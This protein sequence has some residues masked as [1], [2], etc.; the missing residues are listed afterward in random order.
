MKRE[1]L[2]GNCG[3]YCS[4]LTTSWVPNVVVPHV[5]LQWTLSRAYRIKISQIMFV[6][7]HQVHL[8]CDNEV[9]ECQPRVSRAIYAMS[10]SILLLPEACSLDLHALVMSVR[11]IIFTLPSRR[12][13]FIT[14]EHEIL[15]PLLLGIFHCYF[16]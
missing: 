16:I 9:L 4:A 8:A 7:L 12:H 13:R 11:Y 10:T 5:I 14:S 2:Q 1:S 15:P 6:R 3:G